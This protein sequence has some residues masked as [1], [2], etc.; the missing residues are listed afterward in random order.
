MIDAID[1][2][3]ARAKDHPTLRA[4]HRFHRKHP[5]V[6]DFL[7]QEIQLRIEH[8]FSAFS[9]HSLWQ[10]ARWKLEMEKGPGDTFLM[11]DHAAPFYARAIT[12]L[13]PEFNGRA[14]FRKSKA[15]S[16]FGTR[17][18]PAPEKRPK[19]YARRLQWEN[20]ASIERGWRPTVPHTV[21]AVLRKADIH[22]R[23]E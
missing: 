13:H 1:E 16:I 7:A 10:Y 19:N 17:I 5:E 4:F 15:D 23:G 3:V 18:E 14:E 12:I 6:F 20:G 11:N 9:Y 21:H 22:G 8:G 2:L